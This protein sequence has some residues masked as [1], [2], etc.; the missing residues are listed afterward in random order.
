MSG[1]DLGGMFEDLQNKLAATFNDLN[2]QLD[3][4]FKDADAYLVDETDD[5]KA[6]M[7]DIKSKT[8]SSEDWV[9]AKLDKCDQIEEAEM[10]TFKTNFGSCVKSIDAETRSLERE[11]YEAQAE[12]C[13]LAKVAAENWNGCD[14]VVFASKMLKRADGTDTEE[15]DAGVKFVVSMVLASIEEAVKY[16]EVMKAAFASKFNKLPQDIVMRVSQPKKTE[17]G[18]R[19]DGDEFDFTSVVQ[20]SQQ[21]AGAIKNQVEGMTQSDIITAIKNEPDMMAALGITDDDLTNL[22]NDMTVG[23]VQEMVSN[24][25]SNAPVYLSSLFFVFMLCRM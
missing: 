5:F 2:S 15:I 1:A 16:A 13:R 24:L 4:F 19:L 17:S 10:T 22:S 25:G 9:L 6:A 12:S 7:A 20:T 14:G 11:G 23:G 18:R 3:S 21:D 8:A